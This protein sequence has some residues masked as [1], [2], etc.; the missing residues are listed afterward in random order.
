MTEQIQNMIEQQQEPFGL[1]ND[2]GTQFTKFYGVPKGVTAIISVQGT[3]DILEIVNPND[4]RPP[5]F[6][7]RE[8]LRVSEDIELN[9]VQ[10]EDYVE[11]SDI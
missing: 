7:L 8:E 5:F 3:Q 1:P 2:P 10:E 9:V 11:P 6:R 4:G